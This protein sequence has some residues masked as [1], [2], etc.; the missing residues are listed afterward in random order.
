MSPCMLTLEK[1]EI[2]LTKPIFLLPDC[3]QKL[4]V[5]TH[6]KR[7]EK[8]LNSNCPG[9]CHIFLLEKKLYKTSHSKRDLKNCGFRIWTSHIRKRWTLQFK[10]IRKFEIAA[11]IFRNRLCNILLRE[12]ERVYFAK[13]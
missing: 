11:C 3:F 9:L 6:S 8:N 2:R 7:P 13:D 5:A 1:Y 10:K 12:S 4:Y